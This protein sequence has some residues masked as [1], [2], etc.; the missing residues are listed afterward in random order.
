[1]NRFF[2][3]MTTIVLAMSGLMADFGGQPGQFGPN[4]PKVL[5]ANVPRIPQL[6]RPSTLQF[7]GCSD[8][9]S[10]G[11]PILLAYQA[12]NIIE[13][14]MKQQTQGSFV[15]YIYYKDAAAACLFSKLYTLIFEIRD[16]SGAYFVGILFDNPSNGIGSVKF[17]KF[18]LNGNLD[19]VK[20][21]LGVTS[22]CQDQSYTCGDLKSI[23]SSFGNDPRYDLPQQYPGQNRNSIPPSLLKSLKELTNK[24]TSPAIYN[25]D[26]D[27]SHFINQNNHYLNS[28]L[29]GT[30]LTNAENLLSLAAKFED[31]RCHPQGERIVETL[32]MTCELGP[33][34]ALLPGYLTN[35]KIVY[36]IP[37]TTLFETSPLYG[38]STP[39]VISTT[40]N[41]SLGGNVDRIVLYYGQDRTWWAVKTF[42]ANNNTIQT[43]L[44]GAAITV[45][46]ILDPTF[47]PPRVDLKVTEFV[48]IWGGWITPNT[49]AVLNYFGF[50]KYV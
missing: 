24:N 36:R 42:D 17:L 50:I 38:D 48:G 16:P 11:S 23:F 34:V 33:I 8:I 13:N 10:I 5:G 19:V 26:C 21:V 4:F 6:D 43:V 32:I 35:V 18:I 30:R 44:C 45:V 1:M 2:V 14:I 27:P 40:T 31:A 39:P 7:P 3:R 29:T 46:T 12:E 20:K 37:F 28:A 15:R 41:I 22:N 47:A 9:Q 49:D 25:R